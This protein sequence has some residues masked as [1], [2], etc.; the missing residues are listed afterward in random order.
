MNDYKVIALNKGGRLYFYPI[1]KYEFHYECY[2]KFAIDENINFKNPLDLI[3]DG[4]CFFCNLDDGELL[5][6]LPVELSENQSKVFDSIY[7]YL[8]DVKFIHVYF[9]DINN[10]YSYDKNCVDNLKAFV[11][12]CY[13][14]KR[15]KAI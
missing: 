6:F 13:F 11:D 5:V 15:K 8:N 2:E 9:G 1:D 7:K 14:K 12:D 10:Y 4:N 3:S